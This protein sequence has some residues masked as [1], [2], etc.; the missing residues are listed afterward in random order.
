[1]SSDNTVPAASPS[2]RPSGEVN[3]ESCIEEPLIGIPKDEDEPIEEPL[4]Q[5]PWWRGNT[6]LYTALASF[7]IIWF[8]L[9]RGPW[10]FQ[11]PINTMTAIHVLAACSFGIFCAVN[12]FYTPSHGPTYRF[13]HIWLGR[14]AMLIGLLSVVT[15]M[16]VLYAEGE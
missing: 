10:R 1:M 5:R 15:G 16:I 8:V 3:G 4:S 9:Q 7:I 13:V 11:F 14:A 6:N 12:V 2:E